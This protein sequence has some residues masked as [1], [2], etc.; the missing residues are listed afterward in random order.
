VIRR[1]GVAL[2]TSSEH[3]RYRAAPSVRR[4]SYRV[5]SSSAPP[6]GQSSNE[7]SRNAPRQ[8]DADANGKPV[9]V[10]NAVE[11]L[12]ELDQPQGNVSLFVFKRLI[13]P[14]K[15]QLQ[16]R[17]NLR[18]FCGKQIMLTASATLKIL[19]DA[20]VQNF[21]ALAPL[22]RRSKVARASPRVG[23]QA[24]PFPMPKLSAPWSRRPRPP[25]PPHFQDVTTENTE[26]LGNFCVRALARRARKQ[27]FPAP[28]AWTC[29]GR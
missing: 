21:V 3:C 24:C 15:A 4:L 5:L 9:R 2:W 22:H 18:A 11:V 12:L 28:L 1:R 29:H 23:G 10:G 17:G 14:V 26:R 16:V 8:V 7:N 13:K 27:H 19:S 25:N 6:T 20:P